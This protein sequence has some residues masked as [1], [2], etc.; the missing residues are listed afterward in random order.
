MKRILYS[1]INIVWNYPESYWNS[2]LLK[3][4]RVPNLKL[5]CNADIIPVTLPASVTWIILMSLILVKN[6]DKVLTLLFFASL[7][8]THKRLKDFWLLYGLQQV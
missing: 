1:A 6:E 2:L 8:Y 5:Y 4:E 3:V 7:S